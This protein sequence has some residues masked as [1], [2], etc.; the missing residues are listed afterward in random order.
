MNDLSDKKIYQWKTDIFNTQYA[1]V[2]DFNN[3]DS[4]FKRKHEINGTLYVKQ[5]NGHIDT[6]NNSLSS[7]FNKISGVQNN[8]LDIDT[9]YDTLMIYTSSALFFTKISLLFRILS[10]FVAF[11]A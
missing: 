10:S 8:I 5:C 1:L 4:I 9:W 7:V 6:I 11:H 3:T 2:K